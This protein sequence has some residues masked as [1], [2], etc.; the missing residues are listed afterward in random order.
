MYYFLFFSSYRSTKQCFDLENSENTCPYIS[1][2]VETRL[3]EWQKDLLS[4]CESSSETVGDNGGDKPIVL[5]QHDPDVKEV[6]FV[7]AN[8]DLKPVASC[9]S[10][11]ARWFGKLMKPITSALKTT[12]S[13]RRGSENGGGNPETGSGLQ[14]GSGT[15]MGR[16]GGSGSGKGR[17]SGKGSGSGSGSGGGPIN[18]P[19]I[20][21]F[22]SFRQGNGRSKRQLKPFGFSLGDSSGGSSGGLSGPSIDH[23]DADGGSKNGV[24][25]GE[26]G[27]VISLP[28]LEA[29]SLNDLRRMDFKR[30]CR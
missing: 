27:D 28:G 26:L 25:S 19:G 18:F 7:T 2:Y 17:G 12:G 30:G 9:L 13:T 8:C 22:P 3:D 11:I 6:K 16:G 15:L 24:V 21:D 29:I 1:D 10:R 5:S 20:G 23:R 4:N 14:S